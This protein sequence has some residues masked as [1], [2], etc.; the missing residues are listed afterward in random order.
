MQ[1]ATATHRPLLDTEQAAEYLGTSARHL[2][3][4]RAERI[5]PAL[6][7]GGLVRFHPDD[8][9]AFVESCRERT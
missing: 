1:D 5:V 3:R 2:R 8:L 6:R 9:D 7:L 4:L